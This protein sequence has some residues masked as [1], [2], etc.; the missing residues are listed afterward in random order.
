MNSQ[1]KAQIQ[2]CRISKSPFLN[3]EFE[4]LGLEPRF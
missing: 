1:F 3:Q 2:V 4:I